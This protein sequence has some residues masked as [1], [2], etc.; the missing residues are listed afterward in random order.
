MGFET[1]GSYEDGYIDKP[2]AHYEVVA[3]LYEDG[4]FDPLVGKV[5]AR[6]SMNSYDRD[7]LMQDTM[8][9]VLCK[10]QMVEAFQ[11]PGG[12]SYVYRSISNMAIDQWRSRN[13]RPE[14]HTT[15]L[16]SK[17]V[18]DPDSS[19]QTPSFLP[20]TPDATPHA[21]NKVIVDK[22][23]D[24]LSNEQQ[25]V[26]ALRYW[27]GLYDSEISERLGIP[28]GTVKSH[29]RLALRSMRAQMKR[30]GIEQPGDL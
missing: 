19:G 13:A 25:K 30:Q 11:G 29:I 15:D 22:L 3:S 8:Y 21:E 18:M 6:H 26:V 27:D 2:P 20:V 1:N 5:G 16:E 7:D 14:G 10:P 24:G 28:L 9:S 23:L 4:F 17:V 12:S